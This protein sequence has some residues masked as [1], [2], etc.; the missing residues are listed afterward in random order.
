MVIKS[1]IADYQNILFVPKGVYSSTGVLRFQS[2]GSSGGAVL[3]CM[4]HDDIDNTVEI[5]VTSIDDVLECAD[6]TFIKMDLEGAEWEALHGAER[7]ILRNKP[8]LGICIYHSN[9]DRL[10]LIEY[11]HDLVPEYHF[12]IRQHSKLLNETVLYAILD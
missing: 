6:A 12:Y 4:R 1:N 9:E 3:D 2:D 11:I 5:D 10:R 8:K 7:T